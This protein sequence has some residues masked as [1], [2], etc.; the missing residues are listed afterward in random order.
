L[1]SVAATWTAKIGVCRL[2][3]E[4][5]GV[6]AQSMHSGLSPPHAG[7]VML[8]AA[9]RALHR[10][11]AIGVER[12][13]ASRLNSTPDGFAPA[14]KPGL[15]Q[16]FIEEVPHYDQDVIAS[17]KDICTY[18]YE[19]YGRFPAHVDAFH[20]LGIWVQAHH[21]ALDYYDSLHIGGYSNTQARRDSLWH[22]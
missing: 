20:V 12:R 5:S 7:R 14:F 22:A 18:I 21:L 6:V 16:T 9:R 1:M 10:P 15:A 19:T 11:I 4:E 17:A 13:C 3:L 8:H 2:R